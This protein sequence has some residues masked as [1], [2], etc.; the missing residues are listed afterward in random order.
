MTKLFFRLITFLIGAVL[1]LC[2]ALALLIYS[3]GLANRAIP[4]LPEPPEIN[5][6]ALPLPSSERLDEFGELTGVNIPDLVIPDV[7]KEEGG[8]PLSE[9]VERRPLVDKVPA[10]QQLSGEAPVIGTNLFLAILMALIFGV[11]TTLLDNMWREEQHRIQAW[12]D[13]LG[14]TKPVAWLGKVIGWSATAGIRKGCFT[15]PIVV[16]MIALYGIIFALLEQGTSIL[17]PDGAVLAVALAFAVGLISF[18][19]DIARRILARSWEL[20]S[21][22]HLYPISLLA[23]IG[24]VGLSVLLQ[25]TPGIIFGAPAGVD[26]DNMPENK[27]KRREAALGILEIVLVSFFGAVAWFLSG[28]V[29]DA[30]LLQISP[31]FVDNIALVLTLIQNVSLI[32]FLIALETAF[33]SLLPLAY[34][35]GQ[36]IMKWNWFIWLVLFVPVAFLFNH[37]LLNPQSEFL[38]SFFTSN[39]RFMWVVLLSLI[40]FTGLLWFYFNIMD[41]VL[42][43]WFGIV[44]PSAQAEA[45]I[46]APTVPLQPYQPYPVRYD[47][48]GGFYDQY[49]NYH[50]PPPPPQG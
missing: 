19:G 49:G 27:R 2:A 18:S 33:F 16:A 1:F 31:E 40:S 44:T 21:S 45:Q 36:S 5:T 7:V 14:V 28:Q 37:A 9:V 23:A 15:L 47:Q 8:V 50:P 32:V 3:T 39:V 35:S 34:G 10:P 12:L 48:Y 26:F 4:S 42:K 17:S 41:D 20:P 29:L 30:L 22:F 6:E 11:C 24:S 13:W 46:N 25:L 38:S 43:E